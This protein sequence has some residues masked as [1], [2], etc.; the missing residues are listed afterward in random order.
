MTHHV[1]HQHISASARTAPLSPG[2]ESG[3]DRTAAAPHDVLVGPTG[4]AGTTSAAPRVDDLLAAWM[5]S[6]LRADAIDIAAVMELGR[7]RDWLSGIGDDA[8]A[9]LVGVLV[10]GAPIESTATAL[11]MLVDRIMLLESGSMQRE[12]L[13]RRRRDQRESRQLA[14]SLGILRSER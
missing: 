6:A 10:E 8:F 13:S 4:P 1:S 2:R 11:E 12:A 5:D 3:K 9:S 7:R 14:R